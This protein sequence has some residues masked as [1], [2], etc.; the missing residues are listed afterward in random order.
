M[1]YVPTVVGVQ[2]T[3][4]M[5]TEVHPGGSPVHVKLKPPDPLADSTEKVTEPP[6]RMLE[7][8]ASGELT[9]G[10]RKTVT[11]TIPVPEFEAYS[12]TPLSDT[13]AQ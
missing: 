5:L 8:V 1:L 7:G 10:S 9:I 2:L 12:G 3:T 6:N 11:V 13:T 4:D